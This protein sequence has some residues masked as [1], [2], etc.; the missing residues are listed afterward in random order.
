MGN[1]IEI[2][3]A[4]K[5]FKQKEVFTDVNLNIQKGKSY[6]VVGY[7]GCGKSVLFKCICGFSRLT[8][9]EIK[10]NGEV[11]GKD[12][13]FI[14]DAGV[15]IESPDF[16]GHLSGFKNLCMIAKIQK[17]VT[18]DEILETLKLVGLY[19][20]RDKKYKAYSLGMKQKL[21]L[22]QAIMEHPS[23]LILDEPTNGLDKDSVKKLYQILNDF[24]A[25]GGTL[26]LCSHNK[27]D[28]EACCEEVYEFDHANLVRVK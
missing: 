2:N 25:N 5:S 15:V 27:A 17:K 9:G 16:L 4:S 21:R 28:I 18:E 1:I 14:R 11:I 20:E 26:L 24:L 12:V 7:N 3:H 10:V 23:I 19:D 13:D 22:A 6:G 8:S